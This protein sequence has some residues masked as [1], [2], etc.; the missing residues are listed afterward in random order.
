MIKS[1]RI[2]RLHL[3]CGER[4]CGYQRVLERDG[5]SVRRVKAVTKN[6]GKGHK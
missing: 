1:Q 2:S 6:K 3:G 5:K 4:L